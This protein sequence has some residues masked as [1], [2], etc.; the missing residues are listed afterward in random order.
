[1]VNR[2][3]FR[4]MPQ[5]MLSM[6]L[7]QL[8]NPV[9][10][11]RADHTVLYAN[12]LAREKL[13]V[14]AGTMLLNQDCV[15]VVPHWSAVTL[16][17]RDTETAQ[18]IFRFMKDDVLY[19][20]FMKRLFFKDGCPDLFLLSVQEEDSAYDLYFDCKASNPAE[21][22]DTFAHP[23]ER[24][25]SNSPEM[26]PVLNLCRR[27][28]KSDM[29]ILFQGE[30]GTGKTMLAE[31][32]HTQSP[33]KKG[34]FIVLNCAA[35]AKELLES[36]LFGYAPYAFT[37]ANA[38]GKAGLFELANH[39]TLLLDEIGDMPLDLQAKILSAVETQS[40]MPVGGS[41]AK[42]VDV[43]I[44]AA[45][46]RDLKE[47]VRSGEFREDLLWRLNML[48]V[49][50]PPLRERREDILY[51]ADHFRGTYNE[52][53]GTDIR[54]TPEL[55]VF[56]Q[57]YDWPGNVRQLKNTV[58]KMLF[59][60]R[61][62]E[63]PLSAARSLFAP[64]QDA[65][66]L[67]YA[68]RI[69]TRERRFIQSQY[70]RYPS[71][72]KLAAALD[73]SQST[74]T[75]LIQK[76]VKAPSVESG[77][78]SAIAHHT[79]SENKQGRLTQQ[80]LYQILDGI[81]NYVCVVDQDLVCV[82]D[83]YRA[84]AH[85]E[86]RRSSSSPTT[87]MYKAGYKMA[88][89]KKQPVTLSYTTASGKQRQT[90][91]AP[92]RNENGGAELYASVSQIQYS[93]QT[94]NHL[95]NIHS[96]KQQIHVGNQSYAFFCASPEMQLFLQDADRAAW[97]ELPVLIQGKSGTGKSVFARYLHEVG[98][99]KDQPFVSINCASIP[100][101]LI[102]SELFGYEKGAFTGA[103]PQGK[104]GLFEA[105][106]GGT[107]FLDEIGDMP[108]S[109]QA[110]ILDVIENKRFIP[111][112]G[113]QTVYVDVRIICATNRNLQQL[114]QEK[115]F[116]E[117][118]FWRINVIQL[119]VPDLRQRSEDVERYA[120]FF[121]EQCCKKYNEN[122]QFSPDVLQTF[123][124]YDW[125]GNLR[126]LSNMVERSFVMSDSDCIHVSDL[127]EELQNTAS[128]FYYNNLQRHWEQEIFSEALQQYGSAR[129]AASALKISNAT[130]S[131]KRSTAS[132]KKREVI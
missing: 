72:R 28:A 132:R 23:A 58:E 43:R 22:S 123:A 32:V 12:Q 77:A 105:A 98:N 113:Q 124:L 106:N 1:M 89:S 15:P 82:A 127:P 117:D 50:I 125:P 47:M 33:R 60:A 45:T 92:I 110:K 65:T 11:I 34:P 79:L 53:N 51:L 95:K 70:Q 24:F 130:V 78:S 129:E 7:E 8:P 122:K 68:E 102:E 66:A 21:D 85:L 49:Q 109:A 121:L 59:M 101:N 111:I 91:I 54:F 29:T 26:M 10:A 93:A 6:I 27:G 13:D 30:S 31:Y 81:P 57:D 99:R 35:I 84:Q 61:D 67:S 46:N 5:E 104:P 48:E 94:L 76:Y 80:Q 103:N 96:G 108:L 112:G 41:T 2:E 73:I 62:L 20:A 114:I 88:K 107:L 90:I 25:L 116:R 86:V 87:A 3:V 115:K 69:E 83:K 44:L 16:L 71:T 17:S 126:Q 9:F 39:G 55:E 75:R 42:P 36:E 52:Q 64:R 128:C 131:R 56:L 97:Q 37:N 14:S 118:L 18:D 19:L 63:I 40:I 120:A 100:Q 119:N 74:A 4:Q 38:K